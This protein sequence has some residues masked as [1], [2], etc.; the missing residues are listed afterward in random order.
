MVESRTVMGEIRQIFITNADQS[1]LEKLLFTREFHVG[2]DKQHL[3]NLKQELRQAIVVESKHV[4]GNVVTM[5]SRIRLTN[6]DTGEEMTWTLVF[7][8]KAN[9]DA[10]FI[11]I[12]A[13]MGTALIGCTTG[14]TIEVEVPSGKTYVRINEILYQPEAAGDYHL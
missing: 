13:P 10:D 12:L 2:K 8:W 11:S 5:N 6:L 3:D 14:E 9:I 7:P 1:R 4:S